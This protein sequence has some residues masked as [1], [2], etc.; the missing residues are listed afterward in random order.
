LAKEDDQAIW[1]ASLEAAQTSQKLGFARLDDLFTFLQQH[2]GVNHQR[3]PET[4]GS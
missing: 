3:P 1:R 2:F 4:P